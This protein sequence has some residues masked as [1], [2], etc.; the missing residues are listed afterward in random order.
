[1]NSTIADDGFRYVEEDEDGHDEVH[2]NEGGVFDNGHDVADL[3]FSRID[4]VAAEPKDDDGTHIEDDED[5]GE[6]DGIGPGQLRFFGRQIGKHP[7]FSG[8]FIAA[9]IK[10]PND[11]HADDVV[12][13]QVGQFVQL[14]LDGPDDGQGPFLDDNH[15]GD[16]HDHQAQDDEAHFKTFIEG[17]AQADENH[18]GHGKNHIDALRED[19][20]NF[21]DVPRSP[22]EQGAR[23]VFRK[24]G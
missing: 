18:E 19:G 21:F 7:D 11:R 2:Q 15:E 8:F 3:Q 5:T 9:A 4:L 14:L 6:A 20:L 13:D 16:H 22:H 24:I 17:K 12:A 10:G 1:M 23:A